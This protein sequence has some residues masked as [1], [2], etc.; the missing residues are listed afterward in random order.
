MP[1]GQTPAAGNPMAW[2]P[3]HSHM[4]SRHAGGG[5]HAGRLQKWF[6]CCFVASFVQ[7]TLSVPSAENE[8]QR[9]LSLFAGSHSITHVEVM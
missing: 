1:L 9:T 7:D 6:S 3:G 4:P 2:H 5:G 8:S